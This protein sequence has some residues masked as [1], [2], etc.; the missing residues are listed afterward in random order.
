MGEN[1]LSRLTPSVKKGIPERPQTLRYPEIKNNS[2]ADYGQ[3]KAEAIP[4]RSLTPP[5]ACGK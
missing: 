1:S 4:N 2:S 5:Q 3:S